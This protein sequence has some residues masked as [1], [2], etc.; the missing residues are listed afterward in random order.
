MCVWRAF[1]SSASSLCPKQSRLNRSTR[2]D[3][4]PPNP[5]W[6]ANKSH[7]NPAHPF[8]CIPFTQADGPIDPNQQAA[9]AQDRI[10]RAVRAFRAILDRW[11]VCAALPALES[12]AGRQRRPGS[13]GSTHPH[14]SSLLLLLLF[15]HCAHAHAAGALPP[16]SHPARLIGDM[17]TYLLPRPN[18]TR[19][20]GA[21][22]Q[23]WNDDDD[24]DDGE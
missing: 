20:E 3:L 15:I 19:Q 21:M 7:H 11:A 1:V 14:P 9:G 5:P 10:E 17:S 24:A 13:G 4:L 22:A 8:P 2:F 6:Q 16:S 12:C 18:R 23:D